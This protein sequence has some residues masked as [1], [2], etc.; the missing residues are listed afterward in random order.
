MNKIT[1]RV[2]TGHNADGKAVILQDGPVPKVYDQLGQEGLVFMEVWETRATPAPIVAKENEPTDHELHLVPPKNG[3]RI[4][5]LD[6]PTDKATFGEN[7]AAEAKQIFDRIGAGSAHTANAPHPFMHRTETVDF[8][9]VLDGEL[10]LIL[11]EG[12]TTVRAGDIVVQRGTNHA[13]SNRS[14][15]PCRIAFVLIDG[16]FGPGLK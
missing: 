1:R 13:W 11:D 5:V 7:V 3:V 16:A 10:V 12:E 8:G 6:I 2:V 9:I 15:R 14:D 4:R